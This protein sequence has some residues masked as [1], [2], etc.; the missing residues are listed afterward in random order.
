MII[1]RTQPI[2]ALPSQVSVLKQKLYI[3]I[4]LICICWAQAL[5][6]NWAEL[7]PVEENTA[8]VMREINVKKLLQKWKG[9]KVKNLGWDGVLT[10][11]HILGGQSP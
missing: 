7:V 6:H 9:V 10:Q 2:A 1:W 3:Q 5:Y 8:P 4:S 11:Q